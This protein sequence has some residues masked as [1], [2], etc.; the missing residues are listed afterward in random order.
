MKFLKNEGKNFRNTFENIINV[1]LAWFL[2]GLNNQ[3]STQLLQ[4]SE[5]SQFQYFPILL[6][7]PF[8]TLLYPSFVLLFFSNRSVSNISVN[9]EKYRNCCISELWRSWAN[10]W[11]F[12]P[13]RNYVRT[14]CRMLS[15][16]LRKFLPSFFR[17][18]IFFY[19]C[20]QTDQTWYP[21]PSEKCNFFLKILQHENRPIS[22][23]RPSF[24][25]RHT[26]N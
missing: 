19:D 9:F 10:C 11:L 2:K 25:K 8:F 18:F 17:I 13:F 7:F 16:V 5:I 22:K 20:P 23:L 26:G 12:D 15:K 3:Q 21:P 1:V 24:D 4:S 14:T 6:K